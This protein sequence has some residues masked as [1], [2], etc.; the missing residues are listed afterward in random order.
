MKKLT[1][2]I[3]ILFLVLGLFMTT[4]ISGVA[5]GKD[6]INV[7]VAAPPRTMNPHGAD[8]DSNMSVMGNIFEGLLYRDAAGKLGPGLAT[9][10][11]R[12]DD[13]TWRFTL[14]KG[15][16][17]HNGNDFNWEDVKFSLLRLKEPYPVS[18][19]L[20]FGG[21]IKSV[22]TVNGDPWTIDVKTTI[23]VPFFAQNLHQIFIMDKE[24]TE[25]RSIGEIGQNPIGTGPY[26]FV[27]WVKGSYLKLTANENYWGEVPSIKNAEI[28]PITEP[29]TR[30]AAI[31]TG[32]VDILQG[33]PVQLFET[34]ANNT[35]LEVITRPARRAMY[36]GL[37]NEPGFPA[38]DIRVRKAIYLA[39]N[40]DEIIEKIMF[41]HATLAAQIPDPPTVGFDP[42]L[43]RLSYDPEKAKSL[44]AEA[45]YPDGFKIKLTGTNDRYVQDAQICEA[46][47]KQLAKV[48]IE[49]ELDVK[50][51]AIFF[52]ERNEHKLDFY[53][54][55]WFDG[56]YDFGRSFTQLLLSVNVEKGYGGS[57][58]ANYSDPTLDKLFEESSEI[59]DPALRAEKLKL[60]NRT[61]MEEKIA[62]IPLHYQED[63]Y[64]VYKGRGIEFTPRADTWILFRE[65][66]IKK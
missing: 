58:G 36:L 13:V 20:A 61:A 60:L 37:R 26:K 38:S 17:F 41:G 43:K 65:I 11:E 46:I 49:V 54:I 51:K 1:P 56:S 66:S 3:V 29:S 50:P 55:G 18:E 24:S 48:G 53:F 27:E 47:A 30:L 34:V 2:I 44:L 59:V 23:P 63:S 31:A 5:A 16:K 25:T 57:N 42:S 7:A 4:L 19:Y 40:E 35:N 32:Q 28:T 14:R 62:V 8:A 10:W 21:I 39:I 33:I 15:V 6:S 9:S 52:P 12:I 22:E 64:A 45:G